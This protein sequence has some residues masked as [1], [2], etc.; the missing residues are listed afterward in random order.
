MWCNRYLF[1][2]SS[3]VETFFYQKIII[4]QKRK[5]FVSQLYHVS[6]NTVLNFTLTFYRFSCSFKNICNLQG[7]NCN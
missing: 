3:F 2:K 6:N 7:Y 1:V 4:K 5:A